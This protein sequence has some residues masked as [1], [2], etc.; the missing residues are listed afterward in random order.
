MMTKKELAKLGMDALRDLQEER[1]AKNYT[2]RVT[3]GTTGGSP[4]L[5]MRRRYTE[6]EGGAQFY[7]RGVERSVF[8]FGA[9][10]SRLSQSSTFLFRSPKGNHDILTVDESDLNPDLDI[11]MRDFKP[12]SFSGIASFIARALAFIQDQKILNGIRALRL[13][14]EALTDAQE[15]FF[16]EKLPHA[17]IE[18]GFGSAEVGNISADPCEFL[19]KNQYHPDPNIKFEV[20]NQE[21]GIGEIAV[22]F[23]LSPSVYIEQYLTGDLCRFVHEPCPCGNSAT[24]EFLGRKDF[25]FI[26][27]SGAT[28]QK[29]E[30][31]RVMDEYSNY[32]DDFR[33]E[34][35]EMRIDDRILPELNFQ[36]IG[37]KKLFQMERPDEF[38]RKEISNNL[39][40]TL[41]QTLGTLVEKGLFL[42]PKIEFVH[43]FPYSNKLVRIKRVQ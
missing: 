34:V 36:I 25:D 28:L 24:F 6:T 37:T 14:A 8:F 9:L 7:Y 41:K 35:K 27:F 23:Y 29:N 26:R 15:K 1:F 2:I 32:I 18:M 31:E 12:D 21:D 39:F 43:S 33:I 11:L 20:V 16:K 10:S 13:S 42:P 30:A 40:L 38:L 3:S 19:G 4:L 5:L 22:S 17:V